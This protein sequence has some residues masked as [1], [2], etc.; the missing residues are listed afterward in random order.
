MAVGP[1][2]NWIVAKCGHGDT[3]YFYLDKWFNIRTKVCEAQW[4]ALCEAYDIEKDDFV[5]FTYVASD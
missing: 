4:G 5:K 3:Y 1:L 2:K